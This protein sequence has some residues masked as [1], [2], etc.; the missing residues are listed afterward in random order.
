MKGL[1]TLLCLGAMFVLT[2]ATAKADNVY[3]CTG[4]SATKYH[5]VQNCR[6]LNS[7]S[8]E[9]KAVTEAT[10]KNNGREKCL[11]CYATNAG[12]AKKTTA[13]VTKV[14]VTPSGTKYHKDK[15]CTLIAKSKNVQEMTL[16][17]AKEKYEPCSKCAAATAKT[18]T[19]KKATEKSAADKK[20]TEK[21]ATEKK[22][23]TSEDKTATA[24]KATGTSKVYVAAGGS[25]YHKKKSCTALAK[26]KDIKSVTLAEAKTNM[27][28]CSV[29]YASAKNTATKTTEKRAT[30][31]KKATEKK[32]TTSE[33]KT[34]TATKATGTSKVYVA[35]GGS[36]YHKKK[37]CT[38]LA[39]S[40]DI[41]SVT[42][43][44]A[45]ARMTP[46][47]VCYTSAKKAATKTTDKKETEKKATEKKA[48]TEK[49]TT[50]RKAA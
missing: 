21:K 14:F 16:T 27:T 3:I 5:K 46:C 7:C 12:A 39:K 45:K 4:H 19:E 6:G 50:T 24:T 22:A 13:T 28:P 18:A 17:A 30:T 29:C 47:S 34:A 31:E 33:E 15:A 42:L 48:T 32:A 41:K 49:K 9:V 1:K 40:K 44:E 10:A 37:S 36:K 25:K 2:T 11:I 38:A 26:S 23:T 35:A 8:G 43:A 20:T